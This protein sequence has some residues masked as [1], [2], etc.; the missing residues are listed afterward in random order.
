M[1]GLAQPGSSEDLI[2]A[3]RA[4]VQSLDGSWKVRAALS[5][6]LRRMLP[7][8]ENRLVIV[9]EDNTLEGLGG[10]LSP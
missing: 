1:V 10:P 9:R 2:V 3:T 6:P 7:L 4:G 8:G 5:R